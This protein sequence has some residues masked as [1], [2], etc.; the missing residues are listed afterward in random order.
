MHQ[1]LSGAGPVDAVTGQAMAI[2]RR[3]TAWGWEGQDVA[4]FRDP[5][6]GDAVGSLGT[7]R[8]RPG[9]LQL[10]HYSAYAPR[11]RRMLDP[12]HPTL[13]L[14]HNVTPARY[15]WDHEPGEAIVCA[16]GRRQL[17]DFVA[18]ARACAGVSAYNAAELAEAGAVDPTVVPLFIDFDTMGPRDGD[19]D[20]PGPPTVLCVGRLTPHKRHDEV[21]RAFAR[22][23]ARHAPEA[24]LEL[25]GEA[26]GP[27]Y[28][29][30]VGA[31]ADELAPGAVR[32]AAG[33][34]REELL[35]RYRAAHVLLSLS[36]HEGF[37]LPLIEAFHHGVPVVARAA[38]A[39]PETTG[40]AALLAGWEDDDSVVAELV[41]L[42]ISDA[43]LRVELRRRGRARLADYAPQR[44]EQALR[45]ALERVTSG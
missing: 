31:L 43:D 11:L 29:A 10:L 33:L 23:R 40:D 24:R 19:A 30:A 39:V 27:R 14:S 20:P 4:V 7:L 45:I 6:V 28:R 34:S 18:G 35:A 26:V 5:R 21:I 16:L 1:L 41:H 8:R 36:E 2:R 32:I 42:A 22:Y 13:L 44:A 3:V 25:V 12:A 15:L 17:A 9:D 37:C 38:A